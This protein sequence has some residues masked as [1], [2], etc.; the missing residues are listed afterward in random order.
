MNFHFSN[1]VLQLLELFYSTKNGL[2]SLNLYLRII[3]PVFQRFSENADVAKLVIF[4][5]QVV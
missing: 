2:P 5:Q 1:S 3:L 4:H